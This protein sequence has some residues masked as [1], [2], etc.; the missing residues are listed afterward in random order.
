MTK[1]LTQTEMMRRINESPELRE[2]YL[3]ELNNRNFIWS[4]N[5]CKINGKRVGIQKFILFQKRVAQSIYQ[6]N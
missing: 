3:Q 1:G 4:R 2:K 5:G 6:N